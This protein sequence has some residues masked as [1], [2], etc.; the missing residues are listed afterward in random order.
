MD[1]SRANAVWFVFLASNILGVWIESINNPAVLPFS[2][3]DWTAFEL[4][5]LTPVDLVVTDP[6][7]NAT[8]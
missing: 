6:D 7:A 4:D 2:F 3:L 8:Y 1:L 5:L